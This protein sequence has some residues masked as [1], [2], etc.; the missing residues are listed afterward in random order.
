MLRHIQLRGRTRG[1]TG[2]VEWDAMEEER[3]AGET[4]KGRQAPGVST[5][6]FVLAWLLL[7]D[8]KGFADEFN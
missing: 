2:Q 4:G 3:V 8:I 1:G 5:F 7:Q 6:Y